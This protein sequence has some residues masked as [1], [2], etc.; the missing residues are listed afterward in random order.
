MEKI[1]KAKEFK[2]F[3]VIDTETRGL[4]ARPEAFVFGVV[5]A[6]NF[7]KVFTDRVEM[8]TWLLS[9]K[10]PFKYI[11]AHNAEYDFT[12]LYDNIILNL[13]NSALFVGSTFVQ[14][15]KN[16]KVFSNSLTIL[17]SSVEQLGKHL[18]ME[19]GFIDEKFIRGD[20][21]IKV[22]SEDIKYC[23][24]DCE[25][26]YVYLEK[27]FKHTN[28]IKATVASCAME[29]FKEEF[30][31]RKFKKN[32]LNEKFRHSY[33]G[34]RVEC[35][36]FGKINPCYKYD[37]NSLYP[38]VCTKMFFPDFNKMKQGKK[39]T[40]QHFEKYILPNYEGAAFVTVEHEK[41]F[42]GVLPFRKISEIIFPYGIFSAWYN[43]NE[44]R[45]ALK[46]GLV[47][48]KRI[49]EFVF[50]PRIQFTELREYMLHFYRLKDESQGAEK[51][52]NKFFL[53]SL[54]GKFAQKEY[55]HKTYFSNKTDA[56]QFVNSLRGG[57]RV[58]LHHFSEDRD[59]IF[60]EVFDERRS[61]KITWNI[62]TI[63]SYI[64]S[65]ARLV[66]LPFF[67]KYQK[68]LLYTDTDS[69]VL[70]KP[71]DRKYISEN[72][73][74]CFKKE[75]DTEIEIIGN[76]HYSSKVKGERIYHIKGV[77]KNFKRRGKNFKF[78]KMIKTKE[79]I[80]RQIHAGMFVEVVKHMTGD[81]SKRTVKNNKTQ[82]LK[83]TEK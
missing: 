69:L 52:L 34:G 41:S 54:T 20:A 64:T 15:K 42:V 61:K 26:I 60:V 30:L 56:F 59:D 79:S 4:K 19:K 24:R 65:E 5:Y 63:S 39:C 12:V 57:E 18:G 62:P 17:K 11:F 72:I 14:A 75:D 25:I 76:K 48:I 67:L 68:N 50:A 35:F 47:K 43:F 10:N 49:K 9:P 8:A 44:L 22:N 33:Y 73:L 2:N 55:G 58:E 45:F 1:K 82:T 80:N 81:Y 31:V 71:L 46:T 38:Y 51:L 16:K 37:I 7:H 21:K 74:G 53:N 29:I 66:M 70:D 6:H 32:P 23:T 83:L 77:S 40:I 36:R 27:V 28:K 13:D 3:C 78:R